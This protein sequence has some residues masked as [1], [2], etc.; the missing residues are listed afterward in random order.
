MVASAK[1]IHELLQTQAKAVKPKLTCPH[2]CFNWYTARLIREGYAMSAP[3]IFI[4]EASHRI[5]KELAEQTGQT[6][7]DLLDKALDAYR[8]KLF[9]EQLNAGYAELRADPKAWA[10]H[11][12]ER[13][14]WDATLMDGLDPDE[15]WTDDG[16][17]LT[18]E[19]GQP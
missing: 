11:L 15:R 1:V 9:F 14:L 6:M 12:A 7:M 16:H 18:P 3:S 4:S 8:R 19:Q 2:L 17:C 5:L 10:D 13:K